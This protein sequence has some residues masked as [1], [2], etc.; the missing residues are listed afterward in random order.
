MV[1]TAVNMKHS[2]FWDITPYS[3]LKVKRLFG[4]TY[5]QHLR[6][7]RISRALCLPPAFALVFYTTYFST[8]KMV[9]TCSSE[10][11]VEFQHI[12]EDRTL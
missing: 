11:S 1:L 8:V 3:P 4:G 9:A 6:G 2:V 7:R 5:R 10:T 12:H